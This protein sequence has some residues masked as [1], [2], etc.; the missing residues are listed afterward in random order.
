MH[1][2]VVK[3]REIIG[4]VLFVIGWERSGSFA[5]QSHSVIR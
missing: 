5:N 1:I 3:H 4:F 2:T